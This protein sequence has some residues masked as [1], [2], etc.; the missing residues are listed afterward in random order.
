MSST[1]SNPIDLD[2]VG[3]ASP[4]KADWNDMTG[5]ERVRHCGSCDLDVYDL[6]AMRRDEAEAFLASRAGAERTCVRFFRRTDGR[7]LTRDC[8]VG[9]RA[10]WRRTTWAAAALLAGGFAAA[11]MFAP[12]GTGVS[13]VTP[14]KEVFEFVRSTFGAP[15]A[16]PPIMGKL[17]CPP[18]PKSLLRNVNGE[19]AAPRSTK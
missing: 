15:P 5:D 11:A 14:F 4:C 12:R 13:R 19:E 1:T 10:A 9:V 16:P 2:R 6:S 18:L 7:L 17:A 3:I 8:P